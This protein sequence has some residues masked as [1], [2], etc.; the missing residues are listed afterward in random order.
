MKFNQYLYS[1]FGAYSSNINVRIKKTINTNWKFNYFPSGVEFLEPANP[2]YDDSRW[3]P[4]AVP[5]TWSTYE[6]TGELH[7]FIMNASETDD[8]YWWYGW[9]WYRKHLIIN[10]EY[11][12]KKFFLEFDGV[13]KYCRI[14]VNGQFVGDHKGGF[15]SFALDITDYIIFDRDNLLAVAVSN[16]RNDKFGGIP[17]MTAGNWDVYGGIYRDVRLVIKDKIYIPYQG[18]ADCEG[19]LFITTPAV[20]DERGNVNIITYVKNE[21]SMARECRVCNYI[22][23]ATDELIAKLESSYRIGSGE[24]YPCY[25]KSRD[26]AKPHLWSPEDPYLYKIMTFVEL[27]GK[28]VDNYQSPLGFRWFAWDYGENRLY[29]NG[30]R[31]NL[32]GTN[33]HQE[34]PW[35]GD[36]IPKWMHEA[37]Y[38]DI[39]FNL[40][41]NFVR[42]CHYPQDPLVYDLCDQYGIIVCEEVPNIKHLNFGKEIQESNVKEMIRRDRNHPCIMFWSMGNET[43]NPAD[44]AWALAEDDTR[45]IHFRHCL[46]KGATARHTHKNM[47][48]EKPLRCAVR[49]WYNSDVKNFE[50][51]DPQHTGNEE[52]QCRSAIARSDPDGNGLNINGSVWLYNDHGAD[53]EYVNCPLK[54]INPKGWVDSYRI[55]KYMYYLWMANW[56]EKPMIFIHPYDWTRRYLGQ[57]RDITVNSNCESI[58]LKVNGVNKGVLFPNKLNSFTVVFRGI[59]VSDGIITAEGK[60]GE[61]HVTNSVRMAGLP[62]KLALT[63]SHNEITAD[64][65]GIAIIKADI[66]D[67]NGIHVFGAT[68]EINW[69]ISGPGKLLGPEKYI[70]DIDKC[71]AMSGTMY[72]DAPVGMPIRSTDTPGV[73]KVTVTSP[74]LV[75][76]AIEINSLV[77]PENSIKGIIEP[78]VSINDVISIS[79]KAYVPEVEEVEIS[80]FRLVTITED[81]HWTTASFAEYIEKIDVFIKDRNRASSMVDYNMQCYR[82]LVEVMAHHL[83]ENQ[84][85][86]VADDF[87]FMVNRFNV[88]SKICAYIDTLSFD[89][90]RKTALKEVYSEEMIRKGEE[91]DYNEE[92]KKITRRNCEGG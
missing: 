32:H 46:G 60:K 6:T 42:T 30:K 34:Y 27:N 79:R 83:V 22:M 5:H 18:L 65:T 90:R 82:I 61:I 50:P 89:S 9:G 45:I 41:H 44:P 72:I 7:P 58:A 78:P 64:R 8:Q 88:C 57:T 62:A 33:R 52:H 20:S 10:S 3:L 49:G 25:Q 13:Q 19:G 1:Q 87:N 17:P 36:A 15:T 37:D 71:E 81:L 54:H 28:V 84:G 73:I 56:S 2:D 40:G 47:Q 12:S 39:R 86:L 23:D 70:S 55:P 80:Y 75:D 67:Q 29:L 43:C 63:T 53:R 92:V 31:V 48:L 69:K 85:L 38:T 91:K 77:A 24:T 16:R 59:K 76:A 74:G 14:W 35:L 68:N 51:I 21:Y 26:V 66:L 4:V 11:I